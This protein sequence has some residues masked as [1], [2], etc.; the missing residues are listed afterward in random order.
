MELLSVFQGHVAFKS[1]INRTRFYTQVLNTLES[2][3]V[4]KIDFDLC[5]FF[6]D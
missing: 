2:N 6:L 4:A 1:E 5:V 3:I